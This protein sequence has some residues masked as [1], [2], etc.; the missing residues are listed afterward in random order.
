MSLTLY[1][2]RVPAHSAV[3]DATVQEWL[4]YAAITLD[5][6]AFGSL[7]TSAQVW[8]AAHYYETDP[9][10]GNTGH[11]GALSSAKAGSESV[12]YAVMTPDNAADAW[13]QSTEYGRRFLHL[14]GMVASVRTPRFVGVR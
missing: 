11:P 8:L 1:R 3:A 5:A 7:Y 9:G 4:D 12:S 10:G 6:Q 2:T 13:L 14:R